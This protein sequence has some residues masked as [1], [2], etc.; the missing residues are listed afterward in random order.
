[1]RILYHHRTQGEEP[2]SIHINAVV[3]ALRELGHDVRIVGPTDVGREAPSDSSIHWMVRVKRAVPRAVFELLQI[4]YNVVA[5]RRLR[6][7]VDDFKPDLI[8]ERYALFGFAGVLFARRRGIPLILE[9][10]TPYAQAWAK[11][12]G[13]HLQRLGHWI[14]RR[15]LLGA[16][17]IITVTQA[18]RTLLQGLG[19]AASR[20]SVSHNAIDPDWFSN[21]K[22]LDPRI[23]THLGLQ[24]LVVGFVGTMNRWQGIPQ[25][26]QVIG[27]VLNQCSNVS[28]L[29]VGDGEFRPELEDFCRSN[30]FGSRVVFTGRKP[31]REVP[32]L[33]AV[34][35]IAVLLD[36]NSYGSPM[37][38][39]EYWAM[40]KAV[41][42]PS[43][44]PVL[45][46]LSAG[47]TGL[48][49]EP[50]NAQQMV[51]RIVQLARDA[52]LRERLGSAGRAYV[53]ANHTWRNNASEIVR[54][55]E[56]LALAAACHGEAQ[57]DV[58][59]QQPRLAPMAAWL[60]A[61]RA[62]PRR[63]CLG[64][65]LA[66]DA[67][68]ISDLRS[69]R[70]ASRRDA[71]RSAGGASPTV[72]DGLS[73]IPAAVPPGVRARTVAHLVLSAA[74]RRGASACACKHGLRRR[75][76]SRTALSP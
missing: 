66:V 5:L 47:E 61:R 67:R 12:F 8:Y 42:A 21:D 38:I 70:A 59:D 2:E 28:F 15:T 9:V 75:R 11:Y 23:R 62:V 29:F 18:Q 46:V 36:S 27:D 76:R 20:I 13:L 17:H 54:V 55:H 56:C 74:S 51:D 1:M 43:V 39:F 73:P 19:I 64:T 53:V 44:A 14:E 30:G 33:V 10:N 6:Q 31:H 65:P 48:L 60:S 37:K 72:A 49:I 16:D 50:G 58:L 45:E 3:V 40:G 34:M 35:D 71:R 41:I 7:A 24:D 26:K 4:A 63:Q 68:H 25:F 22:H 57:P 69:L 32:P 52:H